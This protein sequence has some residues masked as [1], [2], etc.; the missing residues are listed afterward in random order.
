MQH[1]TT[2][3]M[4]RFTKSLPIE[5]VEKIIDNAPD[6]QTFIACSLVCKEW[7]FRCRF[8]L[9][10]RISLRAGDAGDV[11]PFLSGPTQYK[12]GA[13]T[14]SLIV[15][16]S[17]PELLSNQ[18]NSRETGR[19]LVSALPNVREI[20]MFGVTEWALERY[21]DG[22]ILRDLRNRENKGNEARDPV[23]LE[24]LTLSDVK[25][26]DWKAV[27][28]RLTRCSDSLKCLRISSL[29]FIA[30]SADPSIREKQAT[31]RLQTT[32]DSAITDEPHKSDRQP[33]DDFVEL[34]RLTPSQASFTNMERLA[35]EGEHGGSRFANSLLQE[36]AP[37]PTSPL[38]KLTV[39][40]LFFPLPSHTQVLFCA[41][42]ETINELTIHCNTFVT[43]VDAS[44]QSRVKMDFRHLK[45][46]T[47][48][49][50]VGIRVFPSA[51]ASQVFG[52]FLSGL[53][54]YMY[55]KLKILHLSYKAGLGQS[56]HTID[57]WNEL[58]EVLSSPHLTTSLQSLELNG[59]MSI[60]SQMSRYLPNARERRII[61]L[62]S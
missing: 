44:N 24:D 14:H 30:G 57:Q 7:L 40:E 50:V 11:L 48:F 36:I 47:R 23:L 21:L 38:P 13:F 28:E 58:D 12:A 17:N 4:S 15:T 41:A 31:E 39:L 61:R 55:S 19:K 37:T 45:A 34:E 8:Y 25:V 60:A 29:H 49:S 20:Q 33:V 22:F 32:L 26:E 42:G 5:I 18:K 9:F 56:P 62:I 1:S 10:Q 6:G 53:K 27:Q 46:L 54:S 52:G 51:T 35:L 16:E 3:N 43:A 59:I 2:T